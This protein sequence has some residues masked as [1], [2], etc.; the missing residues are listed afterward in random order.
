MPFRLFRLALISD[1]RRLFV[2]SSDGLSRE[3]YHFNYS[4]SRRMT[5]FASVF[6]QSDQNEISSNGIGLSASSK[7]NTEH[8]L[9]HFSSVDLG[10]VS[11]STRESLSP[12]SQPGDRV[13]SYPDAPATTETLSEDSSSIFTGESRFRKQDETV[14]MCH[15]SPIL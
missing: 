13:S 5:S 10:G 7:L 12:S 8:E 6:G 2:Y 3:H 9:V 15:S 4:I 11:P 1:C 14:R